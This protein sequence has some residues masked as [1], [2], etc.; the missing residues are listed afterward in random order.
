MTNIK[1]GD[2]YTCIHSKEKCVIN[3]VIKKGK[4]Y[5]ISFIPDGYEYALLTSK[6]QFLK[7]YHQ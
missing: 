1:R 6:T 7:E 2:I 5:Q 4:G 3:N